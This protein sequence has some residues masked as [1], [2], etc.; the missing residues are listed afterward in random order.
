MHSQHLHSP[1]DMDIFFPWGKQAKR[2]LREF[3]HH[4]LGT[5]GA[6]RAEDSPALIPWASHSCR[7]RAAR[8]ALATAISNREN[9]IPTAGNSW[10]REQGDIPNAL[11]SS[12]PGGGWVLPPTKAGCRQQET[13]RGLPP[14]CQVIKTNLCM[15]IS[16]YIQHI[17]IYTHTHTPYIHT[18]AHLE[19]S[20]YK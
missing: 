7:H 1:A 6:K 2:P 4:P 13:P 15:C 14:H 18:Q 8:G 11:Y 17:N 5:A 16:L 19:F 9:A 12:P 10:E 3:C 20:V